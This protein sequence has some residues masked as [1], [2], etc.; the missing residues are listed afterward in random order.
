[1]YV[2]RTRGIPESSQAE[3][4]RHDITDGWLTG[5]CLKQIRPHHHAGGDVPVGKECAKENPMSKH[6]L[7]TNDDGIGADGIRRL[8]ETACRF[9][10]VTVVAPDA[11]R[12]ASSHHCIFS[13]PLILQEYDFGITGVKAYTLD[14][15]PA[16]CVRVGI[17]AAT[18]TR[19]DVVLSGINHGFNIS[20]D[21]QYSGTVGAALEAAFLGVHAIAVSYGNYQYNATDIVDRFLPGL[22]EE[23]MDKPLPANQI[24]NINIPD[25]PADGCRGIRRNAVMNT[26]YFYDDRYMKEKVDEKT[27]AVTNA[28]GRIWKGPE[29]SDLNAVINQYI[30]VGTVTNLT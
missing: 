19:P 26:E 14:G 29:N 4:I 27:W 20:S 25:C 7:I 9:G 11:Q 8:A 6:I 18:D 28:I 24:W 3:L 13:R 2:S 21:I 1:M 10:E 15:T 12:S 23:Y 17:F 30:S 16:D 5:M 22:L